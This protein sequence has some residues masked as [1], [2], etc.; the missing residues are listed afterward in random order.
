[1]KKIILSLLTL[2]TIVGLSAAPINEQQARKIAT[3][4]FAQ[5]GRAT[6]TTLTLAWAGDDLN[7]I[8]GRSATTNSNNFSLLY[9]YNRG[10]NGFAIV[11]G[12]DS[13]EHPVI[14]YS[15]ER[16]FDINKIA[17]A[18][19]ELL[20]AW[21]KQIAAAAGS[22]RAASRA[23]DYGTDLCHYNTALWDQSEPYN[24]EA[25]TIG[26][27]RCLTG[28]VATAMAI[29]AYYHQWPE[30]GVGTTPEYSIDD[31][32]VP[33]NTLGRTYDYANML[34]NY[35][36][37]YTDTQ[38]D[39][40]AALMKDMGTSVQMGYGVNESWAYFA[41]VA[42]SMINHFGYSKQTLLKT[43]YGYTYDEWVAALQQNLVHCGPTFMGAQ[44]HNYTGG[45]AFILEG[46]TSTGYFY[47]NYGWSG[48]GNGCYLLPDF[49]YYRDQ[50][51][52]FDMVP[53]R[54]G[55]STYQ[56]YLELITVSTN[57]RGL[58]SIATEYKPNEPFGLYIG[59]IHNMGNVAFT[60]QVQIA[61]CDKTGTVKE[62]LATLNVDQLERQYY[63]STSGYVKFTSTLAEGDRLRLLYK[64]QYSGDEW[65]W[66]KAADANAAS[67]IIL[68]ATP[69]DIAE[70]LVFTYLKDANSIQL[71]APL[72][73]QYSV[74]DALGNTK[75]EGAA[76]SYTYITIDTGMLE[77]GEYTFSIASGG[78]PYL[79]TVVL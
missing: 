70:N 47:V 67:E 15:Q 48:Y 56:D 12:D 62:S 63:T 31:L 44:N 14:A 2:L 10:T 76:P 32:V 21:S 66:A 43:E 78:K 17:P 33:A 57:Y 71:Y 35:S 37:G 16:A 22:P 49:D 40:V 75:A 45:H 8:G 24:R 41:P 27:Q 68:V 77:A 23:I 34:S 13:I 55:T 19:R 1:M 6:S 9:I 26:G 18:T 5:G 38:G 30:K 39:A 59:G 50:T 65:H 7:A 25:P 29:I 28:C 20:T 58:R 3:D 52:A 53:D 74:T 46:C 42:T 61:L 72:A 36:N 54:T 79:F 11:A 73:L 4:F 69:K 60:G 51:V 64:G